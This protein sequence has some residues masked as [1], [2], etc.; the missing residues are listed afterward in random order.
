MLL[1]PV[2]S[3]GQT[4]IITD[5]VLRH[6]LRHRQKLPFQKEA[7]GQL[8]ARCAGDEVQVV[9]ATG[10]RETDRRGRNFYYPD[11]GREREE[12]TVRYQSGLH[13]VG[14][15]HTHPTRYPSPSDVD[16]RN[17]GEIV[18]RSEHQ[19]NAFVLVIVGTA[20]LPEGLYVSVNDGINNVR[21]QS[22][23]RQPV[24]GGR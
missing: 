24:R 16:V 5:P 23:L 4:I 20:K 9:E 3:S 10:P 15:W 18:S 22:A 6:F 14:D 12:I 17:I 8:F 21:L 19:L 2:G 11:R 7:G 13:Y 1:Y